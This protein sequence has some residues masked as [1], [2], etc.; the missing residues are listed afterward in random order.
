MGKPGWDM[1]VDFAREPQQNPHIAWSAI[2]TTL[3]NLAIAGK[4]KQLAAATALALPTNLTNANGPL[5]SYLPPTTTKYPIF[6]QFA[7]HGILT[8]IQVA[9]SPI[10]LTTTFAGIAVL[11]PK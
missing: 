6:N 11:I 9:H 8:G 1:T 3:W 2:D 7:K 5:I 4:A 10:V